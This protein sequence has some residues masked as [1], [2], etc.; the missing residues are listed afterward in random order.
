MHE[1]WSILPA[2]ITYTRSKIYTNMVVDEHRIQ[3]S[4]IVVVMVFAF[5]VVT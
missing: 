2:N 3:R 1:L 5:V 4:K